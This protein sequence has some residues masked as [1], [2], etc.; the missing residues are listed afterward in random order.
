MHGA[1]FVEVASAEEFAVVSRE[2]LDGVMA[3]VFPELREGL[4]TRP[5]AALPGGAPLEPWGE[6][7][8]VLGI[9]N[10]GRDDPVLGMRRTAFTEK[11]WQRML[12][13]L[14]EY[15]FSAGISITPLDDR[16]F[17]LHKAW[18]DAGVER[19]VLSPEWV[20]LWFMAPAEYTGWPASAPVQ[21]RWAGFVR[22][23][24]VRAGACAGGLSDDRWPG[25]DTALEYATGNWAW[26]RQLREVLRGYSW[27]TV[28]AGE[29]AGRLGGPEVLRASGAFCEVTPLRDGAVW[30]RATPAINDYTGER[31]RK[32]F[33]VLAP[34]LITGTARFEHG[35][36]WRLV[37][38]A[39][40]ADYR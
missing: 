28:L 30:L 3:E 27:V 32:V 7:G 18:A 1:L 12:A 15:P 14:D 9:L 24:A 35:S 40:A 5:A 39:D 31:I 16:G 33:E 10:F 4:R 29:L 8:Q 20:K 38:G 6:P 17:Q 36:S 2:W 19:D 13:R 25:G 22:R 37:E 21:D 34:V 26:T 23:E 11:R